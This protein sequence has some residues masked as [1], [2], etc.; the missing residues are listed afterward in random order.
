MNIKHTVID[1]ELI[2]LKQTCSNSTCKGHLKLQRCHVRNSTSPLYATCLVVHLSG[3]QTL[4]IQI[5]MAIGWKET[6]G[7]YEFGILLMRNVVFLKKGTVSD[8]C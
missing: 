5:K 2:I 4:K 7:I 1:S 8:V 3:T 6:C